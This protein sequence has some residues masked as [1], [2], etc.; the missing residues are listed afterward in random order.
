[1][2][3]SKVKF[4]A[5]LATREP[6]RN[7]IS[8]NSALLLKSKFQAMLVTSREL[9]V[10]LFSDKLMVWP[11]L[12]QKHSLSTKVEMSLPTLNTLP[13]WKMSLLITQQDSMR[14]S[15][16][17][18]VFK[19]VSPATLSQSLQKPFMPSLELRLHRSMTPLVSHGVAKA[20]A[21]LIAKLKKRQSQYSTAWNR[22]QRVCN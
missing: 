21:P 2:S 15:L 14:P 17:L 19:E 10:R 22:S 12:L 1:L 4:Q 11:V 3:Q 20:R 5:T 6:L 16:K 18:L 8:L 13:W 9:K 7:Q